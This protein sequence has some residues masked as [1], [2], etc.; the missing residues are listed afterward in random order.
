[1]MNND[2]STWRQKLFPH[3]VL[4]AILFLSWLMLMHSVAVVYLIGAIIISIVIPKITQFFIEPAQKKIRWLTAFR[5]MSVVFYDII[6]ANIQVS[7]LIL[8]PRLRL[9]SQWVRV[10]LDTNHAQINTLLALIVTTTPGTVSAGLDDDR[11]DLLVHALNTLDKQS[12]IAEIKTRYEQ[13]LMSIFNIQASAST[14]QE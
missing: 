14:V 9:N 1:M 11:G 7:K 13:P 5:L 3:P 8:S 10:P 4:S 12:L 2:L 6:V